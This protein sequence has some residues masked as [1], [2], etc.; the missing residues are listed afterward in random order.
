M[1]FQGFETVWYCRLCSVIN[2]QA[3]LLFESS[4][5]TRGISQR[6]KAAL[7]RGNGLERYNL[8]RESE[9]WPWRL[10][11]PCWVVEIPSPRLLLR[12]ALTSPKGWRHIQTILRPECKEYGF[13]VLFT[14]LSDNTNASD[15]KPWTSENASRGIA[16]IIETCRFHN[17]RT[18]IP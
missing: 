4:G 1:N 9:P 6:T 5:I 15:K 16:Y 7:A 3:W 12:E 13:C 2:S 8:G 11:V 18:V 17:L 14:K 10:F